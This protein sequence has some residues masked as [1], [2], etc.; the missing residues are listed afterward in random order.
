MGTL[1]FFVTV[2]ICWRCCIARWCHSGLS[3][4]SVNF[5]L[6]L[7]LVFSWSHVM[8]NGSLSKLMDNSVHDVSSCR[9]LSYAILSGIV[10]LNALYQHP[11]PPAFASSGFAVGGAKGFSLTPNIL[12]VLGNFTKFVHCFIPLPDLYKFTIP[13]IPILLPVWG[14]SPPSE[15]IVLLCFIGCEIANPARTLCTI[16]TLGPPVKKVGHPWVNVTETCC[17][18]EFHFTLLFLVK[19]WRSGRLYTATYRLRKQNSSGF[20]LLVEMAYWPALAVQ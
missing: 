8:H 1:F 16:C 18:V 14:Q 13:S 17:S 12:L 11:V 2:T 15:K 6:R 4:P 19:G 7:R 3:C 9:I 20:G 10:D 5:I